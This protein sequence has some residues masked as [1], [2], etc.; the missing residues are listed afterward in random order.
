[1]SRDENIAALS[2]IIPIVQRRDWSAMGAVLARNIVDH[3]PGDG[4]PP[5]L[6]GIK[7]YWRNFATAFPDF[8]SELV[9]LSADDDYVTMVVDHFGTHLGPYQGH[10]PTGR[11]ISSIRSIHIVKFAKGLGV[12]RWGSTDELEIFRQLGLA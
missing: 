2:T 5:G 10:A 8:T 12:E 3:D 6:E 4:E 7:W 9:V 11:R 1:M